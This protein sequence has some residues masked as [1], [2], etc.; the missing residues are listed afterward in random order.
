MGGHGSYSRITSV[1]EGT[2]LS[3]RLRQENNIKWLSMGGV[4]MGWQGTSRCAQRQ[5]HKG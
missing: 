5:M 3:A 4:S 1:A 2:L